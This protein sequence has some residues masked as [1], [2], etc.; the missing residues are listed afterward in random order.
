MRA[1]TPNERGDTLIE[2]LIAI[3]LIGLMMGALYA[4]ITLG[5]SGSNKHKHLATADRVL[6]NFAEAAKTAARSSCTSSGARFT[7][8]YTVPADVATQG[9]S[10]SS[11]VSGAP[12]NLSQPYDCPDA[13]SD[14]GI[15]VLQLFV[16]IPQISA[17]KELD[18]A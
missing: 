5:A 1:H 9:F 3:A 17:P 18:V 15:T 12:V 11:K 7:V 6:R 10:V 13:T 4:S 16:G 14:P 2:I 8:G